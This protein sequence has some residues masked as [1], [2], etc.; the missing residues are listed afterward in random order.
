M[1]GNTLIDGLNLFYRFDGPEQAPVIILSNPLATN[2]HIWDSVVPFLTKRYR[3]LRYDHRG[4]G[5]TDVPPT[6]CTF[7]RLA[8]DAAALLDVFKIQK[9]TSFVGDSMGAATAIVF[10]GRHPGRSESYILC[11]TITKSYTIDVFGPRVEQAKLKGMD[12]LAVETMERWF[13]VAFRKAYPEVIDKIRKMV[14]STPVG[15]FEASVRALQ[16]F[17]LNPYLKGVDAPALLMVG[18]L[19][20]ELVP[21]MRVMAD[22]IPISTYVVIPNAGHV[23]MVDGSDDFIT[24]LEDFLSSR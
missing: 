22:V 4:H 8:D 24:A 10:S 5:M 21:T 15:G 6:A 14:I 1:E 7:E 2:L 23:P 3:V 11:D 20:T 16:S 12:G 19:D 13:G 9:V 18:E 17:D